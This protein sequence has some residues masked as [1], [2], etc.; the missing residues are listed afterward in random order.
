MTPEKQA[1]IEELAEIARA[2]RDRFAALGMLNIYGRLAEERVQMSKDYAVAEAEM[3]EADA[4][5]K[6]AQQP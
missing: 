1:K 3:L 4:N 2:K 5:L 6:A